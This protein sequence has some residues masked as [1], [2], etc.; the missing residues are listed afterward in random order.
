M[1]PEAVYFGRL[2][3]VKAIIGAVFLG[4]CGMT[5]C[6]DAQSGSYPEH[7]SNDD[8]ADESP[9]TQADID[10]YVAIRQKY[11]NI[12][13]KDQKAVAALA[14]EYGLTHKRHYYVISK[15]PIV[16][17]LAVGA[18]MTYPDYMP[19]SIRPTD[20]EIELVKRNIGKLTAP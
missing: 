7:Y 4:L 2:Q 8:L 1:G 12:D 9:L 17:G 10:A 13:L 18:K 14:E 16:G 20:E 5:A 19:P 6:S 15:L 3:P 11:E